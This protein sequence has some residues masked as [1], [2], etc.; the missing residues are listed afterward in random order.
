MNLYVD[1]SNKYIILVLFND[2]EIAY[3]KLEANRNQ[4]EIF[5]PYLSGFLKENN[6]TLED[7]D[8][9]FFAKGPGSFTGVR[10]GLTYAKAL[11]VSGYNN[12][13]TINS[14]LVLCANLENAQSVIDA[15]GKKYYYQEIIDG[16]IKE[17][18]LIDYDQINIDSVNTYETA[19][20]LIPNNVVNIV[21]NKLYSDDLEILYIK[22]AIS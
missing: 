1:T 10:V 4:A 22:E 7:I 20:D 9:F 12:L 2:S 17:P 18:Q 16:H 21:K 13:Y 3:S 5:V 6:V 11:K 14:L 8:K 19:I 15:R